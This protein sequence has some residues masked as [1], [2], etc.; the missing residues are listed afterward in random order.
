M[1]VSIFPGLRRMTGV[2]RDIRVWLEMGNLEPDA[3]KSF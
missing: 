3:L 2:V 1:S